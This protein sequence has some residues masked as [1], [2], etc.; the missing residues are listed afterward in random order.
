[1]PLIH[2][3]ASIDVHVSHIRAGLPPSVRLNPA[4][5]CMPSPSMML[6]N[7][8]GTPAFLVAVS[9]SRNINENIV[10]YVTSR[11]VSVVV[12]RFIAV[13]RLWSRPDTCVLV[14]PLLVDT[15]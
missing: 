6:S 11:A 10:V 1:M 13:R 7:S 9:F 4:R 5:N 14:L 15:R 2:F 8:A 3:I 12:R